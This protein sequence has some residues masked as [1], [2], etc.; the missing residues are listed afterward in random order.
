MLNGDNAE[1]ARMTLPQ[2][3]GPNST[4]YYSLLLNVPDTAGLTVPN[5]NV[6]ANNDIIIAFNN[7]PGTGPRPS[8]WAG[9]LVI[10]LGSVAN[11][12]NLGIRA[13]T[14][15]AGTT[16]FTG[17]LNPATTY[18]V[19]ARYAS[20][21]TAGTGGVNDLWINPSSATFGLAAPAPDGSTAGHISNT[22]SSDHVD[23]LIIGAGIATGATPNQTNID[24]IRVGETWADVTSVTAFVSVPEPA[25]V[26]LFGIAVIG[27]LAQRRRIP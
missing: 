13:S 8:S 2:Q 20:G 16:Y 26:G 1:I 4:L 25:T 11:T 23:T 19:V 14:T 15:A 5:S 12:F 24:E 27:V 3:Y 22:G 18:L 10:R 6:N 21:A 17:D 7:T 9:E